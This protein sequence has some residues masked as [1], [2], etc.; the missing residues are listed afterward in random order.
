MPRI[1]RIPPAWWDE[2]RRLATA[3]RIIPFAGLPRFVAGADIAFSRDGQQAVA[4]AVVWDRIERRI[5]ETQMARRPVTVPYV[6]GFLSFR[7]GPVLLEA[8]GRLETPWEVICFDGQGVAHPRGCGLA[9]HLGV[10]LDRPAIGVAKSRLCGTHRE[11]GEKRGSHARL[12]LEGRPVGMVLR[13]QD[14]VKPIYLSVGHRM[15]LSS[16]RRIVLACAPRFRIP[17]PTRQADILTRL[18]RD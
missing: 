6:P 13:T 5:V 17:E 10:T 15:D 9:A 18:N 11:P 1:G 2:Q 14:G 4:V 12:M 8:I 7:E 16:A 3:V